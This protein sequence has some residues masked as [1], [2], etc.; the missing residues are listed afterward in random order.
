MISKEELEKIN[1]IQ[2]EVIGLSIVEDLDFVLKKE[3]K[4]GL[5]KLE[6]ELRNLGYSF[7]C[8]E[9][10]K[11][12]RYPISLNM[13]VLVLAQKLF[14]WK[15]ETLRELGRANARAGLMMKLMLRFFI[16]L[17]RT[18]KEAGKYWQ[19]YFTIG[20]LEVEKFQEKEHYFEIVLRNFEGNPNFCRVLEGYFWQIISYVLPKENLKVEEIE[21]PFQGGKVH[22]FK[23]IW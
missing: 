18:I 6:E 7:I 12:Q 21:C 11:Y 3:G 1:Q 10:K 13:L 5:K 15:D 22:R 4:E 16:S 20:K 9:I 14:N 23:V 2:G 19:K 17:E 8:K